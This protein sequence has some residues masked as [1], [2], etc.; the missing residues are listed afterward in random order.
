MAHKRLI[1][2][3]GHRLHVTLI[4]RRGDH[5]SQVAGR[6]EV[7]LGTGE[8]EY[9]ER[10]IDYGNDV[11][12]YLNGI[13]IRLAGENAPETSRSVVV[14]RGAALDDALNSNDTLEFLLDGEAVRIFP[15]NSDRIRW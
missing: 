2:S 6:V 9:R 7:E 1:N 14:Q 4:V 8:E 5:P 12:I 15:T 13:E 10:D 11:D 3:T